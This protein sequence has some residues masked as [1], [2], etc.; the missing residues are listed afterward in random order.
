MR[1]VVSCAEVHQNRERVI[2]MVEGGVQG[3]GMALGLHQLPVRT[4]TQNGKHT[5]TVAT[6]LPNT[7]SEWS[8]LYFK[9][10]YFLR[11]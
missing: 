9:Y 6:S 5:A 1:V 10:N 11:A 2:Q 4:V 3:G 8:L 7:Y